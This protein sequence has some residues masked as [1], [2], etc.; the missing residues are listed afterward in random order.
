MTEASAVAQILITIGGLF[1]L[2]L[3]ADLTGRYTPLPRVTLLLVAGFVIGPSV[4]DWLP[5]FT[6][7]WF[8]VMTDIALAMIGFLLGQNMT[9]TRL[10]QLGR[11]VLTISVGVVLTTALLMFVVLTLLGVSMEIALVLAAIATATA[12]AATVDVAQER[13]AKGKFTD[14]LLGIVAIDDAWG[15]LIF[16]L[17]LSAAQALSGDSAALDAMGAGAWEIGGALLLALVLGLPAAYLTGRIQPGEPTQAEALALVLLC[18]GLAVW[19]EVSYILAAIVLGAVVT[20]FAKHH[21][22]PFRAIKGMEWPFL[23]LFF[24]LAGAALH[25]ESLVQAGWLTAVYVAVRIVARVLGAWLGARLSGADTMT[26]R[27]MGLALL[28]QA[29]VAIGM[30]LFASQRFPDSKNMI[31]PIVLGATVI[32][33][34][35]GPVATRWALVRVG[36]IS[37]KRGR[38]RE[39]P[40]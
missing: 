35:I 23:I 24:L 27:W 32:F 14:M 15:L 38:R 34:L 19:A 33:E 21:E 37:S 13:Q 1:L 8:P 6:E 2:G 22:R 3:I 12:P 20:N 25:V 28:P 16:S 39:V 10:R 36:D 31:L 9:L 40:Q 17:L 18:A 5:G 29:G 30:A 7:E 4:L 11:S 26:S